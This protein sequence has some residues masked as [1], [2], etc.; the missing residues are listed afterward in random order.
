MSSEA[1]A[2]SPADHSPMDITGTCPSSQCGINLSSQ[3]GRGGDKSKF[4]QLLRQCGRRL[5]LACNCVVQT[6]QPGMRVLYYLLSFC[7]IFY[8]YADFLV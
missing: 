8:G 3:V 6:M 5:S 4:G 7:S 1:A 2:C